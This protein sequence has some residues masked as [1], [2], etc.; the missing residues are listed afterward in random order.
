M[1]LLAHIPLLDRKKLSSFCNNNEHKDSFFQDES[2]VAKRWIAGEVRL[3]SCGGLNLRSNVHL[4]SQMTTAIWHFW[5]GP[6][7]RI[8]LTQR[9]DDLQPQSA[10][11]HS[12][13]MTFGSTLLV[14]IYVFAEKNFDH[15]LHPSR[16]KERQLWQSF[17]TL[18]W[19]AYEM[20]VYQQLTEQTSQDTTKSCFPRFTKGLVFALLGAFSVIL[21]GAATTMWVWIRYGEDGY[22]SPMVL[23]PIILFVGVVSFITIC[24]IPFWKQRKKNTT[25]HVVY[26]VQMTHRTDVWTD[27]SSLW[28]LSC[29]F[30]RITRPKAHSAL[31]TLGRMSSETSGHERD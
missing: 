12:K 4:L 28:K 15:K 18:K 27:P 26:Q 21:C 14:Y 7:S 29:R 20:P 16:R 6:A 30:V 2:K 23:G 5:S 31:R 17:F 1:F 19:T 10:R 8:V 3:G 9:A 13:C 11:T 22:H 24:S 25:Y